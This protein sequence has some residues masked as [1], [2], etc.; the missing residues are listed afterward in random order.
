MKNAYKVII[1]VIVTLGLLLII[2]ELIIRVYLYHSIIYDIEMTKY[3]M[4]VKTD[5][6]NLLIG[7]VHKP[8]TS[9]QLMGVNVSINSDGLRDRE[10]PVSKKE[11]YR[12]IVLGDSLTF[13]WGVEE[14]DT[15]VSILEQKINKLYPAEIINFGAGNYNTEQEVNLFIEKGLKYKPD[16]V[17]VFYFINDAELTPKKSK[18]WFLGYSQLISFYWSRINILINKYFPDQSFKDYYSNLYEKNQKGWLNAQKS[19]LRL[20]NIYHQNGIRLQ[21]VLLPEL[22]DV[23]NK[24]FNNEYSKVSAFL[25][26]AGIDYLN[27]ATLFTG[28]D[29]PISLWVAMDD[30]HPNALAHR[31]IADNSFEFIVNKKN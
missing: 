3:A 7:H 1:A 20:K 21:V 19:F 5:S 11:K 29:N 17:V 24:I 16:K 30:A 12:I 13:G 28:Y 9:A 31:M 18:L 22:H 15:F 2:G 25:E 27:L 4:S 10:Y 6:S 14:E 23:D 26:S 8:N